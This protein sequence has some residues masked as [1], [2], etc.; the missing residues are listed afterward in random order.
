VTAEILVESNLRGVDTHGVFL[1]DNYC[2]RLRRGLM[3][4]RPKVGFTRLRT[5]VGMLDG[6]GGLGQ[7]ATH[8]AMGHAIALAKQGGVGAV[9]VT[10]SNHFG[11]A[12]Y[13]AQM[14]AERGCLGMVWSHGE[15]D[16]VPYGGKRKFFGTNPICFAVPAGYE[17]PMYTADMATSQVAFGKIRAAGLA[18][19]E[20]PPGWAVDA[21]GN[22]L[23]RPSSDRAE[24]ARY[25]AVPMAGAKGYGI[26][27][28]IEL[29][30]SVL[31]GMPFGP[32]I[33]RKFDNWDDRAALGHFVQAIDVE[34]FV[35]LDE[36]RRRVDRMFGEVRAVPAAAGFERVLLP[37]EPELQTKARREKQ[38][39]PLSGETVELLGKLGAELGVVFEPG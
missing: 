5:A 16:V 3:N 31:T 13:Y 7:V 6:D 8:T 35:G 38:G 20:I 18:G 34:A 32:H 17:T 12:A 30:C 4:P 21:E 10:N 1:C 11:A 24:I 2:R 25:A 29:T 33:V 15:S 39:C 23:T 19:K 14:A 36:F 9:G 27:V 22:V 37:G 28:F 26:S